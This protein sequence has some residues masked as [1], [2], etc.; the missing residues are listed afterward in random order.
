MVGLVAGDRLQQPGVG[1]GRV[2]VAG[3][4]QATRIGHVPA[5]LGEP[6]VGGL[7]HRRHPRA[8]RVERGTKCLGG[9]VLGERLAEPGGD[10]VAGAGAPLH[11]AAVRHEQHRP[12]DVVGQR[13]RVA[14][15]V[16]GDAARDTVGAGRIGHER[17]RV[18]VGAER[19]TG[20]RE[21]P[22][23][24]IERLTHRL[25]PRARVTRVVHLV[26]DH[27]RLEP[28]GADP[29]RQRVRGDAGVRHGNADVVLAGL[30]L[31]AGVRRIDRDP[32]ARRGFGPL[33]LQVL[34]GGDDGD[35]VDDPPRQ[36]LG[37]HGQ[38]EG[39][40]TRTRG[41]DGEEVLRVVGEVPLHR[42]RLPRAQRRRRPPR[43]TIRVG[44][45]ELEGRS[46]GGRRVGHVS[47]GVR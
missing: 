33:R 47:H 26:E 34:G 45:G 27:Q 29:V 13:V 36:Q 16:V 35:P 3:D 20:Q 6:L 12:H 40:L 37:G 28:L 30:A 25:A 5:Y 41:R 22:L 24:R 15:R 4:D 21:P 18:D 7:Q 43:S 9:H 19:R 2:L 42:R 38:R 39:R 8:T 11:L 1:A 17:D 23:G 10:L 32:G 14:I 31:L 46:L 44:R